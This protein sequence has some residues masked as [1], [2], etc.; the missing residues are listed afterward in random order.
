M[1]VEE[2]KYTALVSDGACELRRYAPV[3]VAE[4]RVTGEMQAA[5]NAGFRLLAGYIF[6]GNDARKSVA[7]T[8]PVTLAAST[9]TKIAMTAPVTLAGREGDWI[10]QFTMPR[11]WSL[12]TLP[13]PNDP[14]VRLR[15]VP[16]ML[17]AVLKF[18]GLT[19]PPRVARKSAELAAWAAE[20]DLEISGTPSLARYDP[21]WTPWFMRR[22]E[23][24]VQVKG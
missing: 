23:V 24:M 10:V 16:E 3:I 4:V 6:G 18:S 9:G 5:T 12:E 7:M 11:Q 13:V 17:M 15:P 20:R 8:A 1:A 2:P 21:P 14:R 22:N 19:S